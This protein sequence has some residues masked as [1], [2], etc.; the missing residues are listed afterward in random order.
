MIQV[1]LASFF[2]SCSATCIRIPLAHT[3]DTAVI[4]IAAK[5]ARKNPFLEAPERGNAGGKTEMDT[6]FS[7]EGESPS[8]VEAL[9]CGPSSSLARAELRKPAMAV[10]LCEGRFGDLDREW[11]FIL[12]YIR[13]FNEFLEER[14]SFMDPTGAC[15]RAVEPRASLGLIYGVI[16]R[17]LSGDFAVVDDAR[18]KAML[19]PFLEDWKRAPFV[20]WE[21]NVWK[22]EGR[23]DATSV[24]S[25]GMCGDPAFRR[26]WRKAIE[27]SKR[28]P[29]V[30]Q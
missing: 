12:H 10:A 27:Y 14:G 25:R 18:L 4:V 23:L 22:R 17:A 2:L 3:D 6:P 9:D 7:G 16:D 26:F 20:I 13:G 28:I 30:G 19:E 8:V 15:S 21:L 1:L 11:L 29:A 24:V 5:D